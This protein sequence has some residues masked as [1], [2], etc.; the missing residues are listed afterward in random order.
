ME[1]AFFMD[2]LKIDS[3]SGNEGPLRERI[4]KYL[5][6]IC[7]SVRTDAVGNIIATWGDPKVVF[8]T[9]LDTVPPYIPPTKQENTVHGRGTC[10]AK[11]QLFG[12]LMACEKLHKEGK[13]G[14]GLLLTTGEEVGSKGAKEFE[15]TSLGNADTKRALLIGEPTSLI[16]AS[17]AKGTRSYKI[18]ISGKSC[19]SGYP[20]LSVNAIEIFND[21]CAFLK[22]YKFPEDPIM[23]KTTWNIGNLHSNN[24][25][26]IVSDSVEFE[27]MFRTTAASKERVQ[28]CIEQFAREH[29]Q[30]TF[31]D[32]G[33]DTPANYY[34][35]EGYE[36][37]PVA[38]GTD[39]PHLKGFEYKSIFGPGSILD[40][41]T[42]HESVNLDD[43]EIAVKVYIDYY[44]K[45]SEVLG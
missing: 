39:A 19:H 7:E 16:F 14:F 2:I 38:F 3:T 33:G 36:G 13:K 8:C 9:H 31:T 22:E 15:Q 5:Y 42:P 11:G 37:T 28:S 27:I 4:I 26:N 25:R 18:G 29:S 40:A 24:P 30:F 43:I 35:P 21:F 34:V 20:H 10:D 45:M 17:S 12:M 41:H 23:G 32:M 6:N 44:K 1:T